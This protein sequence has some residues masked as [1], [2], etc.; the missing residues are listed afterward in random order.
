VA[1]DSADVVLMN[2]RLT[3]VAAA[4]RLSR[5]TLRNIHQNLFWAFFYNLIC[6]PLAAGLFVWKMNPMVGAAAMSLSSF[7]VC[8]NALRLNLFRLYDPSHDR[9][10]RKAPQEPEHIPQAP[11][12]AC[13][14]EPSAAE[15]CACPVSE[16]QK[17]SEAPQRLTVRI[18]G[19]MCPHCE[20]RI[21]KALEGLEGVERAQASFEAGLAEL[22]VS[23]S[24]PEE[25][26][27]AAVEGQDYEYIGIERSQTMKET[28]KI[29][30]MMCQHCA[31]SVK[32][33]LEALEGV[34]SAE[35]SHEAGTAVLTLSRE[36]DD[37]AVKKAVE[38]KDY[39]FAGIEK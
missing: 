7:T 24:V 29:E 25:A 34:E 26:I 22:T 5:G 9:P 20:K 17:A 2:S 38:D 12:P 6:I 14:G 23:Q 27:Q 4:I 11:S 19:M 15:T 31:A 35:V 21:Q 1:I 36:I 18:G 3:D 30:G 32:K 10:L 16:P 28:V 39:T 37:A 13:E 8:M 33:A